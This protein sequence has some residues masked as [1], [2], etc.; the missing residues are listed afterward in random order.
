MKFRPIQL[1][2]AGT[3]LLAGI[4]LVVTD[5]GGLYALSNEAMLGL[6]A[7]TFLGLVSEA[8]AFSVGSTGGTSS[9]I[10]LPLVAA[11]PL[12]GGAPTV[13]FVLLTAAFAEVL[14]RKNPLIKAMFN[15]AQYVNAT[16]VAAFVFALVGGHALVLTASG[17]A[18][19]D[20]QVV[21]VLA[22]GFVALLLNH[23]AVAVA[24][25][26]DR[27][28]RILDFGRFLLHQVGGTILNDAMVMPI[29]LLVAYLY[30][31]L[32]VLGLFVALLPLIFIRY[33]YLSKFK[34]EAA[35]R[36]LLQ[37]LV[38]AIE[39]RDPYTSGHSVRVKDLARDIG[40]A[41]G[42]TMRSAEELE[43]AALLH[44]IGKIEVVYEEILQKP[45][46]LSDEERAIIQSHVDRGVEIL[47][48]LS[49]FNG[50][51]IEG[52]RHHHELWDGS[53]YPDRLKGEQ[54]PLFGRII[55][56]SDAIDAML[57]DRPYRSALSVEEVTRELRRFAGLHFDP[58][59]VRVVLDTEILADYAEM[60]RVTR[61]LDTEDRQL[62][63]VGTSASPTELASRAARLGIPALT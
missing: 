7:L 42:T 47:T 8:S 20:L 57:S 52:V 40:L 12:F 5:W 34:L 24:I 31:E 35:N 27:G 54:I 1:Y 18:A 41:I 2:V 37:A 36:D 55:K 14:I 59:L 4:L 50:R 30:F 22:F 58:E 19:F 56:L 29:A 45:G 11:A 43:T 48:S 26:M 61:S 13:V 32:G 23:L 6:A 62:E 39:T 46:A 17:E 53:G 25:A 44:D 63:T 33:S 9:L 38:K 21:P 3:V 28:E 15:T 16:A 49:S 60:M 10:F 51:I